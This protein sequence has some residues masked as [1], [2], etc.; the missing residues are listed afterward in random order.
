MPTPQQVLKDVFGYSEFRPG[1]A[2]VIDKILQHE[3]V[4][5][6]MPTG[7][8]KSVCYQL[9]AILL[10]GVTIVISPLISLMKDQVDAA[11]E[12]GITASFINSSLSYPQMQQRL[13]TLI[14]GDLQLMYVAPER[15]VMPE[16]QNILQQIDVALIAVD[17]AHCLSQWGHDFRPSYLEMARMLTNLPGQPTIAALTATATETVAK[18]IKQFLAIP[19]S[20]QINTGFQRQN[21]HF[22]LIKDQNKKNYL[23][24]YLKL[25]PH[26]SGIIYASTRKEV[27]KLFVHLQ[28]EGFKVGKYHAG[29]S[30]KERNAYQEAFLYDEIHIMIATNAFGMGINKSNVRFVIHWQTPGTMEAYYQEAGR[31]GRDGLPS[32]AILLFSPADAMIHEFFIEKSEKPHELKQNDYLK[33]RSMSHYGNTDLCL[34]RFILRYFGQ[35]AENCQRCSNCLDDR[36]SQ[37][38][39]LNAQKALSCVRRMQERFGKSMVMKVLTASKDQKVKDFHFDQLSTYGLLKEMTQK[40]VTSL[41]DFLIAAGFLAQDTGEFPILKV[42]PLGIKVLKG[43]EKVFRKEK[44]HAQQ[45]EFSNELFETL[46][47]LRS[48]LAS[49]EHMPAYIIFSDATLKELAEKLPTSRLELL[50]I[51]GIG[52]NKLE[53]YGEAILA[54]MQEHLNKE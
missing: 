4:L 26:A 3:N 47:E 2:E 16:F 28:N 21:L 29:L 49:Q 12:L 44:V 20:N 52:Q 11:S 33:L 31:A 17:E 32:D 8:G 36:V 7:S 25:N 43:E 37:D 51:K 18:D 45:R 38:I 19:D 22:Q 54:V 42:T 30:E 6:L 35:E 15:F 39:T 34:E 14:N 46:R 41:L 40:E 10:E 27:E 13:N 1:Q 53:K 23:I 48:Q 9:P 5:G 24:E 50:Q